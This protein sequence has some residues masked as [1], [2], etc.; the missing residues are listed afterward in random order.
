VLYYG[1]NFKEASG[2]GWICEFGLNLMSWQQCFCKNN[3][4]LPSFS[5]LY[6]NFII[7]KKFDLFLS[8]FPIFIYQGESHGETQEMLPYIFR[9]HP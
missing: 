4:L 1:S 2:L 3:N 9:W 5:S 6:K 8:S 7:N